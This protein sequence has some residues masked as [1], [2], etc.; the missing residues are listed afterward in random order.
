MLVIIHSPAQLQEIIN[1]NRK[2]NRTI[3]FVP[4]M[5]ALH[6]GHLSLVRKCAR[7]TQLCIVSVFVN[8]TQFNDPKDFEKYPVHTQSDVEK[9]LTTRADVLFM[10]S[11]DDMYP[12]GLQT[13]DTIDLGGLDQ[14]MEGRFR[15]GHFQGV[16][17][18]MKKLLLMTQPDKLYM[19]QKDYQQCAVVAHLLKIWKMKTKLVICPTKREKNGLAMSSR[20]ERL[21]PETRAKAGVIKSALYYVKNNYHKLPVE[22]ILEKARLKI[23]EAGFETEYLEIADARN[24]QPVDHSISKNQKLVCCVAVWA[25][26]VRLIDNVLID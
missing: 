18:N 16:A 1:Q 15:P 12:E 14:V 6:E 24:L 2:K 23:R 19:G 26:G 11:V 3:G 21:S 25:D 13:E 9:L 20:N 7:E 5:G 4:T 17:R 8:P 10:P 22:L